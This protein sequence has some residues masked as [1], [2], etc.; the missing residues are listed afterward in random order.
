MLYGHVE[1][2]ADRVAHL[3][4]IRALQDKT[5]GFLCFIPLAFQTGNTRLKNGHGTSGYDDLRTIAV[6]RLFLDNI[7]H[8]KAYWIMIG[9]RTGQVALNFGADDIDGT[10]LEEHIAH[11]AGAGSPQV[12]SEDELKN[13]I[14]SAGKAP[15]RRDSFY[16]TVKGR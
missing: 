7:P 8:I 11:E 15:V 16:A 12:L 2:M 3:S 10:I 4:L 5:K 13:L 9:V 6:S 1:S 14:R